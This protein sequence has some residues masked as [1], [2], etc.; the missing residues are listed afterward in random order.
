MVAI[1]AI[2]GCKKENIGDGYM[3]VRMT[4]APAAYTSVNVDILAIEVHYANE[5]LGNGGWIALSTKAGVYDL[6]SLQNDV[7]ATITDDT[8]LPSGRITQ[9]HLLLGN[10]NS[11]VLS[12]DEVFVLKVPS[13]T[14]SGIKVDVDANVTAGKHLSIVLDFNADKS[15]VAEGRTGQ[16]LLKPVIQVKSVTSY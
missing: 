13:G 1:A 2:V 6:L 7:T 5:Q 9:F 4:D 14:T 3:A 15:V 16:Y 11:L 8:K 12:G 10:N